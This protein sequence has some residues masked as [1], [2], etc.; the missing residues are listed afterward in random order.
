M[1]DPRN[2]PEV[3]YVVREL[4]LAGQGLPGYLL[5]ADV[6]PVDAPGDDGAAYFDAVLEDG[7]HQWVRL[8]RAECWYIQSPLYARLEWIDVGDPSTDGSHISIHG[9]NHPHT[10]E[11]LKR[12]AI[13]AD[14]LFTR[15]RTHSG[16]RTPGVRLNHETDADFLLD[17]DEAIAR[18][19][20]ATGYQIPPVRSVLWQMQHKAK[21]RSGKTYVRDRLKKIV[22]KETLNEYIHRR[23][24][25]IEAH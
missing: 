13:A 2:T 10:D 15:L 21:V 1:S 14:F 16:G 3:D 22:G 18:A 19:Q 9:L 4:S 11:D 17:L 8:L 25:E 24:A 7:Q 12:A 6:E 5:S 23:V 20:Q